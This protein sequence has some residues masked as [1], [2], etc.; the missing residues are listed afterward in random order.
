MLSMNGCPKM[1]KSQKVS[2]KSIYRLSR[3]LVTPGLNPINPLR[4]HLHPIKQMLP[5][6][7]QN[8]LSKA[9]LYSYI[10]FEVILAKW[11]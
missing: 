3:P 1:I 8:G 10:N 11:S 9:K 6:L 4:P 5:K 7:H 2:P